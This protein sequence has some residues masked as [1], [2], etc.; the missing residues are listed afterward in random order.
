M[1]K[2]APPF[3]RGNFRKEKLRGRSGD[4]CWEILGDLDALLCEMPTAPL[5]TRDLAGRIG[6]SPRTLQN[7]VQALYGVGLH[8]YI[9]L[10]RVWSA[11]RQ[12]Q[13]G[14]QSVKAAALENGFWHMGEFS[15]L[16]K[17]TFGEAPSDTLASARHSPPADFSIDF[18]KNDGCTL[19]LAPRRITI[20]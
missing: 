10:M 20:S 13:S 12:L 19:P 15:R 11:Y 18:S 7:A 6:I 9:R 16:Y 4:R 17:S 8:R 2:A 14:R 1:E 5:Y 3:S